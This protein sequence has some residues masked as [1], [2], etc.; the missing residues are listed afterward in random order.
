[1]FN[2]HSPNDIPGRTVAARH[3]RPAL[4]MMCRRQMSADVLRCPVLETQFDCLR[5]ED[6]EAYDPTAR[7]TAR[8]RTPILPLHWRSTARLVEEGRPLGV[9]LTLL[10]DFR[11][12]F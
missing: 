9:S 8:G 1:M 5:E 6:V 11:Y 4:P 3:S 7:L 10:G 12:T 2:P